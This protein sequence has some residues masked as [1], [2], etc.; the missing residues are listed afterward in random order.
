MPLI[1]NALNLRMSAHDAW[2]VAYVVPAV[3]I[4]VIGILDLLITDD[5]P[6]GDW[7]EKKA[8]YAARHVR[9][10]KEDVATITTTTTTTTTNKPNVEPSVG[11]S[12]EEEM[13]MEKPLDSTWDSVVA[14]CRQLGN[15]NVWI[16]MLQYAL[17]FGLELSID[18]VIG[19]FF[20]TRYGLDQTTAALYGSIFG[21]MN[22]FSRASGGFISDAMAKVT[23]RP[24]DGR[25][26]AQVI[27]M[28][29][30]GIFLITFSRIT[31]TLGGAIAGLVLFSFFTQA[32]CGTTFGVL[33]FVVPQTMG[34]GSGLVGAGGNL[35]GLVL[36]FVFKVYGG[37]MEGAFL[38]IGCVTLGVA[39]LSLGLKIQGKMLGI[40]SKKE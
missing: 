1:F 34:V 14:V 20:A 4:T 31:A 21:L 29:L 24:V 25:I 17:S 10:N 15:L 6:E 27:I 36:N 37:N 5:C 30:E 2:R 3:I 26:L 13:L 19:S 35:G 28:S 8:Q 39:F 9:K 12:S 7:S 33:P 38:M 18:N 11:L 22:L 40:F 16:L 32:T 23:P